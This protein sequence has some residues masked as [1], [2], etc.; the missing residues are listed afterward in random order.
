VQ[1]AY[2][3]GSS[4][5]VRLNQLIYPNGRTVSYNF[6]SGMDSTLNRVTSI[7]DTSATLAGYTYLGIGTVVRITYPQPGIWLDLW[8]GT[9]GTFNGIDQFGRAINQLWQNNI[10]AT[11]VAGEERGS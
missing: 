11:P 5:E 7:S 4:N 8:G 9:S 1:Y 2:D 3:S 6:A 10:T